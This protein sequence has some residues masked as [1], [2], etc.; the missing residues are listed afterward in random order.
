MST[1]FFTQDSLIGKTS[2]PTVYARVDGSKVRIYDTFDPSG[3]TNEETVK[4]FLQGI[5]GVGLRADGGIDW[6]NTRV[7]RYSWTQDFSTMPVSGLPSRTSDKYV[8]Y[9]SSNDLLG[10]NADFFATTLGGLKTPSGLKISE[11]TVDVNSPD[12]AGLDRLTVSVDQLT[13]ISKAGAKISN[14]T[15][16]VE[17]GLAAM[18]NLLAI[19]PADLKALGNVAINVTPEQI[20]KLITDKKVSNDIVKGFTDVG[21]K[22]NLAVEDSAGLASLVANNTDLSSFGTLNVRLGSG[23]VSGAGPLASGTD[24]QQMAR[25]QQLG[26]FITAFSGKSLVVDPGVLMKLVSTGVFWDLQPEIGLLKDSIDIRVE[27][28]LDRLV[29]LQTPSDIYHATW[30]IGQGSPFNLTIGDYNVTRAINTFADGLTL[31]SD[32][33]GAT[34]TQDEQN[35]ALNINSKLLRVDSGS[36]FYNWENGQPDHTSDGTVIQRFGGVL[37]EIFNQAYEKAR[38][39]GWWYGASE[40]QPGKNPDQAYAAALAQMAKVELKGS[41]GNLVVTADLVQAALDLGF[42]FAAGDNV[43]VNLSANQQDA[44]KADLVS[45]FQ[46]YDWRIGSQVDFANAGKDGNVDDLNDLKA[47]GL[48]F[49]NWGNAGDI[50]ANGYDD[51]GE[52]VFVPSTGTWVNKIDWMFGYNGT[53][54]EHSFWG[55]TVQG[56]LDGS[57]SDETFLSGGVDGQGNPINVSVGFADLNGDGLPDLPSGDGSGQT[58]SFAFLRSLQASGVDNVVSTSDIVIDLDPADNNG[59]HY[60]LKAVVNF[61]KSTKLAFT[62]QDGQT[63][64]I[65]VDS[66]SP[67]AL[68]YADITALSKKGI[69]LTNADGVGLITL[70]ATAADLLTSLKTITITD[71]AALAQAGVSSVSVADQKKLVLTA[72]QAKAVAVSGLTFASGSYVVL[73]DTAANIGALSAAQISALG[74]MGLNAIDASDNKEITLTDRQ[75]RALM[76]ADIIVDAGDI[77]RAKISDDYLLKALQGGDS[78]LGSVLDQLASVG[79]DRISG[80][81]NGLKMTA[82]MLTDAMPMISTDTN[83]GGLIK[84]SSAAGAVDPKKPLTGIIVTYENDSELTFLPASKASLEALGAKFEQAILKTFGVDGSAGNT[85]AAPTIKMAVGRDIVFKAED[86]LSQRSTDGKT[87]VKLTDLSLVGDNDSFTVRI[88]IGNVA[89]GSSGEVVLAAEQDLF[90]PK[91]L[92]SGED[93][94]PWWGGQP[95]GVPDAYQMFGQNAW[96]FERDWSRDWGGN[97]PSLPRFAFK[98]TDNIKQLV[99]TAN[100]EPLTFRL[101]D[102]EGHEHKFDVE[103]DRGRMDFLNQA[104]G[105]DGITD[106]TPYDSTDDGDGG[107]LGDFVVFRVMD[108]AAFEEAVS[109]FNLPLPQGYWDQANFQQSWQWLQTFISA[110]T[111]T[112][113]SVASSELVTVTLDDVTQNISEGNEYVVHLTGAQLKSGA[114]V[115][116]PN[117]GADGLDDEGNPLVN[118]SFEG[119]RA[120]RTVFSFSNAVNGTDWWRR[121]ETLTVNSDVYGGDPWSYAYQ[122]GGTVTYD[123]NWQPVVN[124]TQREFKLHVKGLDLNADG[125]VNADDERDVTLHATSWSSDQYSAVNDLAHTLSGAPWGPLR[126]YD[127]DPWS[128]LA[129]GIDAEEY[130]T[131]DALRQFVH[132]SGDNG[133]LVADFENPGNMPADTLVF[134]EVGMTEGVGADQDGVDVVESDLYAATGAKHYFGLSAAAKLNAG[135]KL[136]FTITNPA[137]DNQAVFYADITGPLVAANSDP[138][139]LLEAA[140]KASVTADLTF[141]G[142]TTKALLKSNVALTTAK[143]AVLVTLANKAYTIAVETVSEA[144][145]LVVQQSSKDGAGGNVDAKVSAEAYNKAPEVAYSTSAQDVDG[146]FGAHTIGLSSVSVIDDS[147]N[148]Q[149]T[150]SPTRGAY[151]GSFM[152]VDNSLFS[153]FISA[154]HLKVQYMDPTANTLKDAVDKLPV[155]VGKLVITASEFAFDLGGESITYKASD[156]INL[157]L[158]GT[159]FQ[160]NR[161]LYSSEDTFATGFD[162]ALNDEYTAGTSVLKGTFA[163]GSE[164]IYN[165]AVIHETLDDAT[166]DGRIDANDAVIKVSTLRQLATSNNQEGLESGLHATD[167]VSDDSSAGIDND[168]AAAKIFTL[169]NKALAHSFTTELAD[170]LVEEGLST[171]SA[172]YLHADEALQYAALDYAKAG[173]NTIYNETG[174][175]L[176]MTVSEANQLKSLGVGVVGDAEIAFESDTAET[177]VAPLRSLQSL[178]SWA[179]E[180]GDVADYVMSNFGAGDKLDLNA[181]LKIDKAKLAMVADEDAA[182][183]AY[184]TASG[185]KDF[186]LST[187]SLYASKDADADVVD[188][189]YVGWNQSMGET[190]TKAHFQVQL[191]GTDITESTTVDTLKGFLA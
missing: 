176:S 174:A 114:L 171:N 155:G 87:D 12:P 59:E 150:L 4:A 62:R 189:Y 72:D 118:I 186:D 140:M 163:T 191:T 54:P 106:E 158:S 38:Y 117:Y 65:S 164:R 135:D 181:L 103:V 28:S 168:V 74:S 33:G 157:V 46:S 137:N 132:F 151:A 23:L 145:T 70:S 100:G 172:I 5:G 187:N 68:S 175:A 25:T 19:K 146:A 45:T 81:T 56:W 9:V 93:T 104:W 44:S 94:N 131:L 179:A 89:S 83:P 123:S 165:A 53:N 162:L 160:L 125:Q 47:L 190:V 3:G 136:K 115:V 122:N 177:L 188:Y 101:V 39:G 57:V 11:I 185:A 116:T 169:S 119:G 129:H 84:V 183:T 134:S 51:A 49:R 148:L 128:Y 80:T 161:G 107:D 35:D 43:S 63:A 92:P 66:D 6:A 126:T 142:T 58:V 42:R 64:K 184:T 14:V 71:A 69:A 61:L 138:L 17:D 97:D 75:I 20:A 91:V 37:G 139:K 121:G 152:F 99:A 79:L 124:I 127:E 111:L 156:I 76:R 24:E 77:L 143:D 149:V 7:E 159:T 167:S 108:D 105:A 27:A 34:F 15:L 85:V 8:L 180:E 98:Y 16:S 26:E 102:G 109:S 55:A 141:S 96:P 50:D 10:A 30:S 31:V 110:A 133:R 29:S 22:V 86:F 40:S 18:T 1:F 173:F 36:V 112:T 182:L 113:K 52:Q 144:G 82:K 170:M 90:F 130:A 166:G 73:A 41:D 153:Q 60:T 13:K 78:D 154:G 21:I 2:V 67:I 32:N 48:R 95:D 120:E 147:Q 88:K 178:N